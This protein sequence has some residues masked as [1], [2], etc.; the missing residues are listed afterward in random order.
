MSPRDWFLL[1]S[2]TF[3]LP[4][5]RLVAQCCVLHRD[6]V[7][8]L[9]TKNKK[10]KFVFQCEPYVTETSQKC[11]PIAQQM[12]KDACVHQRGCLKLTEG[13]STVSIF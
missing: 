4:A 11:R 3:P 13:V 8:S 6:N 10:K 12:T 1:A 2:P 7:S 9:Q 5:R